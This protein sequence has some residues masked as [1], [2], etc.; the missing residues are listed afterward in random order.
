MPDVG[1]LTAVGVADDGEAWALGPAG[2][3]VHWNGVQW[4]AVLTAAHDGEAVLHGLTVLA[5]NDVWAVGSSYGAP[6]AT[7]WN[8]VAWRP[9]VLPPIPGGGAER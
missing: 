9:A 1:P 8:G 6:Y 4:Q 7:H 3:V 5:A 2:D